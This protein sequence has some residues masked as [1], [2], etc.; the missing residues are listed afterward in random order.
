MNVVLS[1]GGTGGHL[2]PAEALAAVLHARRYKVHLI[3]DGRAKPF[4]DTFP[5]DSVHLVG[6]A[7][8]AGRNAL[9]AAKMAATN[10][11]GLVRALAILKR[12]KADVAVGFGGYPTLAPLTAARLLGVP[13][14]VH[15]ANAVMGRAN[16]FLA[17]HAHVATSFPDV[18]GI[19]EKALTVTRVGMPVREA[20]MAAAKPFV[21]PADGP[22]R[23]L[24]FGGS[25]GARAF[26][27]MVPPAL[28]L[29]PEELQRRLAVTQQVRPEDMDRVRGAYEE[30]PIDATLAPFFRDLPMHMADAHLVIARSG[31]STVME[32][33]VMG[34]P[35]LLVPL[36]GA[37]DQDQAFNASA[38]EAIG[39]AKRLDQAELT[40][41]VL[42]DEIA[43]L[44]G[45][46]DELTAMA[47]AAKGLGRPRAAEELADFA[48]RVG[49]AIAITDIS[50]EERP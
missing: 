7:T 22:F 8:L 45:A 40:P 6:A 35:S 50:A 46:P 29:L 23:I 2:F 39:G 25:Q 42:A 27:D 10:G 38:L 44:M 49:G 18:R 12:K 21:G 19:P 47:D 28:K 32:L 11:V 30:T 36:P 9:A 41:Q 31:A 20:V 3:T 14:I 34:R 37:I 16:H 1:A 13:S 24:V 43:S 4:L 5:A 26:A 15:E 33:A 48:E 17:G